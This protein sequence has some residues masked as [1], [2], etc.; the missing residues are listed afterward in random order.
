MPIYEYE[1]TN[2]GERFELRRGMTDSDSD[3]KCPYC[4]EQQVKRVFSIFGTT[5]SAP[6][7]SPGSFT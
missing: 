6:S 2:C 7:C 1:C 3:I 5:S 4:S